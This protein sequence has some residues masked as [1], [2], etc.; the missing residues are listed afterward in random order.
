MPLVE[1]TSTP[2]YHPVPNP[3][4]DTE[5]QATTA[6]L[7]EALPAL[8]VAN[9]HRLRLGS[10]T[11]ELAVQVTH[12]MF[13]PRDINHPDV[14]VEVRFTEKGISDTRL[15]A[16]RD[17]MR[18]IIFGWYLEQD[19]TLPENFSCDLFWPDA[20]HGFLRFNNGDTSIEW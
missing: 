20:A 18:E 11:T 7:A 1:I 13:G 15:F 9:Q 8:M 12:H 5:L 14:W 3:Q 19:Y 16:I 2:E 4:F 17:N 10:E 6:A